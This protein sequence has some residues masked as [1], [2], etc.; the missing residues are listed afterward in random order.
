M[1][2]IG[3]NTKKTSDGY[4]WRVYGVEFQKPTTSIKTGKCGT[5][6]QAVGMA[7]KWCLYFRRLNGH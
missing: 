3:W 5:R 1:S 6:A 4:E 2:A 7:K